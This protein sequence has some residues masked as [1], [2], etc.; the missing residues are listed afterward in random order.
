MVKE[1]QTT[2]ETTDEAIELA[3]RQLGVERAD[4]E[5][6]VISRG[7]P[8]LFGFGG[9]PAKVT[10]KVLD[11]PNEAVSVPADI[12]SELLSKM[13]VS[14][15]ANL[16]STHNDAYDGPVFEIEGDDA[17]LLIGRK[18]ETLRALQFI[19]RYISSKKVGYRT[20][21]MIDVENYQ[22]RRYS[23]LAKLTEKVAK[24]VIDSGRPV[25]LEPMPSN[26]RRVVHM[27]LADHPEVTTE[28]MGSG[29]SRQVVVYLKDLSE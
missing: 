9:E 10:V 7:K 24:N 18:G 1:I 17:G 3:L 27:T 2:A 22:Q 4:V 16:R 15:M 20:N 19:E 14:A 5:I 23:S 12:L 13:D 6:D 29:D 11:E 8:G 26:E 28:S 25:K 21:L